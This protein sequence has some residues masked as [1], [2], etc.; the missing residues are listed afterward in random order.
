MP[1][2]RWGDKRK[3]LLHAIVVLGRGSRG[4]LRSELRFF[5]DQRIK[6]ERAPHLVLDPRVVTPTSSSIM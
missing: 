4:L 6:K 2:S 3:P 5:E 1:Q